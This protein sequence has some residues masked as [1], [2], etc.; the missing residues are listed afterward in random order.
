M[1]AGTTYSSIA[2]FTS[3]GSSNSVIFSS[4][5]QTY[6]DLVL[7]AEGILATG[8]PYFDIQ[9]NT[10]TSSSSTNYSF[11]RL[12]G[13]SS[14]AYSDRYENW[15]ALQPSLN[16]TQPAACRFEIQS[17]R[18]TNM[19]KTV[20]WRDGNS[21][22]G[23]LMIGLW[24]NTAAIDTITVKQANNLTMPSGVTITLY[25]IEAA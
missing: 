17:Y 19:F 20:I 23:G 15:Y 7:V 12:I 14:T 2:T 8:F 11:V 24:R 5:P 10:D 22:G 1:A 9:F 4:V 6:T 18:N 21:G 16:T 3:T 25:G 13:F